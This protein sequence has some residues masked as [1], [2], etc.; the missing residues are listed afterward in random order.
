MFTTNLLGNIRPGVEKRSLK[1]HWGGENVFQ[2]R[3]LLS[4]DSWGRDHKK[5]KPKNRPRK[6]DLEKPDPGGRAAVSNR[7]AY[8]PRKGPERPFLGKSTGKILSKNALLLRTA[9]VL[10]DKPADNRPKRDAG[11]EAGPREKKIG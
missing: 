7:F 8:S 6:K 5:K 11:Q 9:G 4:A 1:T 10:K 2:T 3:E